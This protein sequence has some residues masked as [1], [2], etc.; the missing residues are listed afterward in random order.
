LMAEKGPQ[1]RNDPRGDRLQMAETV[2]D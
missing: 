2:L 1:L